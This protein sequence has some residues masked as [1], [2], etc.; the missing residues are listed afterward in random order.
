MHAC[1]ISFYKIQGAQKLG[2]L[3]IQKKLRSVVCKNPIMNSSL[4]DMGVSGG[5]LCYASVAASARAI[6]VA[7]LNRL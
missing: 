2:A 6:K 7:T 3:V 4:L 5:T 1:S